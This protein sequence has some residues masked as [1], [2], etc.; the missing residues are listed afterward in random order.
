SY[1][2]LKGCL[3]QLAFTNHASVLVE[4][5]PPEAAAPQNVR[6]A[7]TRAEDGSLRTTFS[8]R[9][10]VGLE[11]RLYLE[12]PRLRVVYE[13][14][15]TSGEDASVSLRSLLTPAPK[16]GESGASPRFFVGSGAESRPVVY[17]S[18]IVGDGVADVSAPRRGAVS[19]SSGRLSFSG[20]PREP[21]VLAFASTLDLTAARFRYTPPKDRAWPL[22]PSSSVGAYW[23]YEDLPRGGSAT[24]SY[25]YEVPVPGTGG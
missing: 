11:Q 8:F 25:T 9:G 19:D 2:I 21:D 7:T 16:V 12:G 18:E 10:G 6:D 24:F 13:L 20:S 1:D 5:R 23:L 15:N 22:P 4:G 17:E 14:S 3:P